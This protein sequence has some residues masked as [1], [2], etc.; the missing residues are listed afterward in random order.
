MSPLEAA[1][2]TRD[3]LLTFAVVQPDRQDVEVALDWMADGR[4]SYWDALLVSTISRAGC[5][6][7][8]TG[9]MQ[10]GAVLMGVEI[11][12][13]FGPHGLSDRAKALLV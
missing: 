9:D 2:L 7:L 12:N 5:A 13:P 6:V 8:M 3:D 1:S 10:D 4:L 11:V